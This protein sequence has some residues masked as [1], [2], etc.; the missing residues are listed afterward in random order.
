MTATGDSRIDRA[1]SLALGDLSVPWTTRSMSQRLLLSESYFKHLF[2]RIVGFPF[3]T[4]LN[5][6]RVH[7]AAKLLRDTPEPVKSIAT[8]V[9]FCDSSHLDN[10]FKQHYGCTPG[11]WREQQKSSLVQHNSVD[12]DIESCCNQ[13]GHK[14]AECYF[15]SEATGVTSTR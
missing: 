15:C 7:R 13:S 5:Q 11:Q 10:R 4:F 9:G 12:P 2:T 6:E 14:F 8:R 3:G 1:I